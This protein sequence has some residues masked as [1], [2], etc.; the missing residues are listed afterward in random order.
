M[1]KK[2]LWKQ[3][4]EFARGF[5]F[6]GVFLGAS[7]ILLFSLR[8]HWPPYR[9][10]VLLSPFLFFTS[11]VLFKNKNQAA[12]TTLLLAEIYWSLS[13]LPLSYIPLAGILTISHYSIF[14]LFK[15]KKPLTTF[16]FFL[17]AVF[18]VLIT[19]HWR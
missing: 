18:L 11:L 13:F 15:R 1:A 2:K 10:M 8:E 9:P 14:N 5:H 16:L 3:F 12:L 4:W 6:F 17:V 19:S 7:L